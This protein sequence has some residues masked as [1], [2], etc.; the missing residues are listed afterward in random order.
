[1]RLKFN[2]LP[3]FAVFFLVFAFSFPLSAQKKLM[4]PAS[5]IPENL[6]KNSN[7][8]VRED[9]TKFEA[10]NIGKGKTYMRFAITILNKKADH[11]AEV[12]I[13]YDNLRKIKSLKGRSF[14][15]SG[16]LITQLKN[17]DIK[18]YSSFDG[19]SIYTDNRIKYFDLRYPDYPYTIEYEVEIEKDG[20]LSFPGWRPYSGFNIS[21]QKSSLEITVP[22]NYNLRY[23]ELNI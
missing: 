10:L 5:D 19:F 22:E 13:G 3:Y 4:Y 9:I 8:V 15:R 20:I 1:M 21:S 6:L 23:E 11:Y 17:K 7:A 14:D 16:R 18:D 12:S 2:F